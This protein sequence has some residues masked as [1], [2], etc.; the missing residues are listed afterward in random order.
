MAR[1]RTRVERAAGLLVLWVVPLIAIA[2]V[3]DPGL[4][5]RQAYFV[6]SLAAFLPEMGR[7]AA[8]SIVMLAAGL[9]LAAAGVALLLPS[10]RAPGPLQ[11]LGAT[12]LLSAG[13]LIL[14]GAGVGLW[15]HHLAA[16]WSFAGG[17]AAEQL[18]QSALTAQQMRFTLAISGIALSLASLLCTGVV[19]HRW[20]GLPSWLLR[21]PIVAGVILA[22]SPLGFI[23]VGIFLLLIASGLVL[24]SWLI[25]EAGWVIAGKRAGDAQG[26]VQD[27][28]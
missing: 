23:T 18:A 21:L 15:V 22:A 6:E 28:R 24:F 17:A 5:T 16:E 11:T 3:L 10:R 4:D 14:S 2:G 26:L 19:F 8:S 12:G 25:I 20:N 27:H 9:V 7:Y 1:S 13:I